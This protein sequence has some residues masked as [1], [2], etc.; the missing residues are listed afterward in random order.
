[1]EMI[2][3]NGEDSRFEAL[4]T[5]LDESLDE[6][7]GGHEQRQKYLQYNG[8]SHIHDVVLILDEGQA[9]ACGGFK[10]F[11][12]HTVEIK[13][14]Y[15]KDEYRGRGL[16]TQLMNALEAAARRKGFTRL[17]LETGVGFAPAIGLY[18]SL[19]F[20]TIENYGQYAGIPFSCCM[21]KTL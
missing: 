14:V 20:H 12:P 4:C 10:Q 11:D 6:Q 16:A 18:H 13:R 2:F 5:Q 1:M 17:V 7:C 15:V 8:L 21:E 3:T 9:V 19:G